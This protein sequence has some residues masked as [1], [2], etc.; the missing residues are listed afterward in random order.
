MDCSQD[1]DYWGVPAIWLEL[2]CETKFAARKKFIR[3]SFT[4]NSVNGDID[5]VIHK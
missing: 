1:L 2:C 3:S 5:Y 4:N